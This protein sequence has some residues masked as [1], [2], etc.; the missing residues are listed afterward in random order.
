MTRSPPGSRITARRLRSSSRRTSGRCNPA[1]SC[2][3]GSPMVSD[4]RFFVLHR[5]DYRKPHDTT[6]LM[7]DGFETG[8]AP[9]CPKC[10][11]GI[12]QR[13]W[14]P[15]FRVELT[16]HGK[17]GAGDFVEC[18][19]SLLISERMAT[20]FRAERLTGLEGFHSVEVV[21]M[22]ARAKRL[23]LPGYLHVEVTYG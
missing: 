18:V 19:G 4:P 22:N 23:E 3:R 11:V 14:L 15:P 5:D 13:E 17:E 7:G 20:A 16:V 10:G 9:K 21:K 1:L 8:D 6:A 2:S 12:G